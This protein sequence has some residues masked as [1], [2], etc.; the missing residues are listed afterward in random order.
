M[1]IEKEWFSSLIPLSQMEYV[2]SGDVKKGK[3]RGTGVI[4]V[5]DHFTFNVVALVDI[6]RYNL[7]SSHSLLMM[8][9]MCFF[10]NLAHEF[11]TLLVILFMVF[12]ALERSFKLTSLLLILL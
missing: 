7:F 3:M 8:I 2:T 11:L 12:L 6:L 5:N 1:T 10:T 4:K 9:S